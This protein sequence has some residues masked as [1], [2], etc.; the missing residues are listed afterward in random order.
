[1]EVR[2]VLNTKP[3]R[4]FLLGALTCALI[5]AQMT[6]TGSISGNMTDPSGQALAGAKV[7]VL[8]TTTSEP[9]T[10]VANE[11]GSFNLIAVQPGVYTLRV[12]HPGFK[13]YER[14]EL[15]VSANERVSLGDIMMQIG[16]VTET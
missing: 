7:T 9:R 8:S 12:E 13:V 2:S 4:L 16:E 1:M 14:R 15:V 3:C 6:V 10:A 5:T 11:T